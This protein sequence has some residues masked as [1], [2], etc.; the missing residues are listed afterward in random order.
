MSGRGALVWRSGMRFEGAK[1][2]GEGVG[3]GWCLGAFT[4]WAAEGIKERT[5]SCSDRM[6]RVVEG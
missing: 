4:R 1:G 6:Q 3:V 2:L 5:Y